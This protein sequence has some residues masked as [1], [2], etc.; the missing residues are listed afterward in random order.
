MTHLTNL[1]TGKHRIVIIGGGFGGLR[2]ARALRRADADITLIDARNFH[3]FQPLLY[4]VA[5]G[6]LSP[7]NIAAP[8]R[9]IL[10]DQPNVRVILGRAEHIDVAGRRVILTDGEVPYDTLIVAAGLRHF[11]FGN[12]SWAA[13]APGLKSIEDATEIR[14]RILLAF[15]AAERETDPQRIKALLTFVVVGAGPTGVELAG[16]LAE[17]ARYTLRGNFRSIDPSQATVLLVEGAER[18]LPTYPNALSA[19]AQ[20]QLEKLGVTV[21]TRTTVST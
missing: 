1:T 7:A 9:A 18:V 12:D 15:E 5:T 19:Q 4:Q 14:R 10:K 2:A 16:A 17:I 6:G 11:Y 20:T 8:L 13:Y 21:Q 3:L